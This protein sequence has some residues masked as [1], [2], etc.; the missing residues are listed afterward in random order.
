[1]DPPEKIKLLLISFHLNHSSVPYMLSKEG[2]EFFKMNQPIGCRDEFTVN[3][4][5]KEI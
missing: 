5:K 2:I 1:M 4:F 3:E